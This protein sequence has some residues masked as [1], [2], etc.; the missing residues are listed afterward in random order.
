MQ[1][2]A[3]KEKKLLEMREVAKKLP[4]KL[5]EALPTPTLVP[6]VTLTRL[7]VQLVEFHREMVNKKDKGTF[8]CIFVYLDFDK[9]N[10]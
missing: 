7:N 4:R 10:P 1:N 9:V 8:K 3:R 6:H 2:V 5:W